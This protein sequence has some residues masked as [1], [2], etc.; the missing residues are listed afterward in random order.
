[1]NARSPFP[2]IIDSLILFID[3]LKVLR[4]LTF[5]P[6]AYVLLDLIRLI[7]TPSPL[8]R[9]CDSS[10]VGLFCDPSSP[11]IRFSHRTHSLVPP[12]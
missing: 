9:L 1:M 3:V 11:E 8:S 5:L 7:E 12:Y 6:L 2:P 4:F 10:T